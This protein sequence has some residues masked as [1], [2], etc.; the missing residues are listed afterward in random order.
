ML[1]FMELIK[2][3][4]PYLP[5]LAIFYIIIDSRV[6]WWLLIKILWKKIRINKSH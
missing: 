6:L 2:L 5:L 4:A 1:T 3:I